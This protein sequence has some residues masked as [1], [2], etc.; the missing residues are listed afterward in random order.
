MKK[1]LAIILCACMLFT[2]VACNS[3]DEPPVSDNG[4]DEQSPAPDTNTD[5]DPDTNPNPD[6]EPDHEQTLAEK[7][8]LSVKASDLNDNM[9]YIFDAAST[10]VKDETVMFIDKTDVKSLLFPIEK[11][12]SVTSYDGTKVYTEG[13][14]FVVEDGKLKLTA[15]TSIPCITSEVYYNHS[16]TTLQTNHD[17]KVCNT[18][19]GEGIA[20]AQ[21]QV[22]VTY[23]HKGTWT[24]AQA[25]CQLEQMQGFVK[26]LIAGEDVTI[27]FY[28]DSTIG[29]SATSF[30][31]NFAPYGD[32]YAMATAK[33]FADLF[34]YTV[35]FRSCADLQAD[36]GKKPYRI[37]TEDYVAGT[38]GTINYVNVAIGGFTSSDGYNYA[39]RFLVKKVNEYGCDLLVMGFGMNDT[40]GNPITTV[41]N[42]QKMISK[43][44]AIKPDVN[45]VLVSTM[46][47][48]PASLG[49][50]AEGYEL[51][52]N[53][54]FKNLAK[55]Y[56][57]EGIG[58]CL[59]NVTEICTDVS[60]I[61]DYH[62]WSGNN[63]NHPNDFFSRIYAQ[64]IIQAVI[65]YEN[66][67]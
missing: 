45:V 42:I 37:P 51:K 25:T 35:K 24:G 48:N 33:A 61:K 9:Q 17:G 39:D 14:D 54:T 62:D 8:G 47:R 34:G 38:N 18:Y 6:P 66:M 22:C 19:W 59:A 64:A 15:N 21:W 27:V 2:I 50:H 32:S 57:D 28:G 60:E 23:S 52:Q 3:S 56:N 16:N 4:G 40:S 20:M 30:V 67:K 7:L 13:T 46:L 11:V 43:V 26:K 10:T 5:P 36:N 65:G 44:T 41:S 31:N 49:R 55:S 29:G 1:L 53:N 63:V 12:I 58:C